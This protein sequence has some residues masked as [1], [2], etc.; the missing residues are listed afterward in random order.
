MIDIYPLIDG[1][2]KDSRQIDI[3]YKKDY[4]DDSE[5]IY[6]RLSAFWI[7]SSEA[8]INQYLNE[9]YSKVYQLRRARIL[10][11]RNLYYC[12]PDNS[13]SDFL[14]TT[15]K[16]FM[17]KSIF[18]QPEFSTPKFEKEFEIFIK[19]M[20]EDHFYFSP[21]SGYK[22]MSGG[23]REVG[24]SYDFEKNTVVEKLF[25]DQQVF[26]AQTNYNDVNRNQ[27]VNINQIYAQIS[28]IQD[29]T[30]FYLPH[31]REYMRL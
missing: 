30:D 3:D 12:I 6:S 20:A 23:S 17:L 11:M 27:D 24:L 5:G 29:H 28:A 2:I 4:S 10:A 8:D 14:L 31:A 7:T 26:A 18:T 22:Q 16:A 1:I 13:T 9:L 19:I 25:G 21:Y 15:F